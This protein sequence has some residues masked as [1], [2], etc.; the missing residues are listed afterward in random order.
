MT[1]PSTVPTEPLDSLIRQLYTTLSA[2]EKQLADTVLAERGALL[3]YSATEL[4]QLAGV[5]K[6]SAAR[7]FRR[8][9]YADFNAFRAQ[10]RAQATGQAPLHRMAQRRSRGAVLERLQEHAGNDG[11]TLGRLA[12]TADEGALQQAVSLL[13]RARRVCVLGFRNGHAVAFYAHSLLH[14]LRANVSLLQDASARESELA[15]DLDARDLVLA[16]D[17]RRRSRRLAPLLAA[18]RSGGAPVLVITDAQVCG[19]E[20]RGD[21]VL[22]CPTHFGQLFDSYVA[23]ISLVNFLAGELAARSEAATRKRL[24]RIEALHLALDDLEREPASNRQTVR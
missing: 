16:V 12:A 18:L 3:G 4:A 1:P 9:G 17:L 21:V 6:A 2:A 11:A 19:I 23:P 24:E 22:R 15:A 14:Q 8:L 7:F 10:L 5:S 20:R 13:A